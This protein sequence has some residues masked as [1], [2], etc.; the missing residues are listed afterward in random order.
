MK[1]GSIGRAISQSKSFLVMS[2]QGI[3]CG[4]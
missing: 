3:Q 1:T 4:F 2:I